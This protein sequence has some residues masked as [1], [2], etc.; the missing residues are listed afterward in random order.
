MSNVIKLNKLSN[1]PVLKVAGIGTS[2]VREE[3][4][5]LL[6][7]QLD[8]YYRMGFKEGQEKTK[9][10]LEQDYSNKL[11]RKYEEVYNI[12]QQYDENLLD[13]EKAFERLVIETSCEIAKKIVQREIEDRS[14]I[15]E[16]IKV[17]INK[18]IGANEVRLKL[19]PTDIE[20]LTVES[21]SMINSSSFTKIKIE[22][23]DRIEKGGC[24][25]ETE[26]GNVDARISTQ[27][28]ELKR[29]LEESLQ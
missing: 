12:L 20:A 1:K 5:D 3:E 16:N 9:R 11:I 28:T 29:K 15:N 27:L 24:L 18:I 17:A 13:M 19:N 14:V 10:D 25:I 7:K 21:K 8:D 26:I 23:D 4:P 6:K 22:G 2:V